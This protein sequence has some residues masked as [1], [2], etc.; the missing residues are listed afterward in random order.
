MD[1]WLNVGVQGG[2]I[3]PSKEINIDFGGNRLCLKPATKDTE[4]SVHINLA[5]ISDRDALTLINRFLSVLS[6]CDD[7]PLENR[8]GWSGNPV[9]AA[10]PR[11]SRI[12]GS[13]TVFPFYRTIEGSKKARLSLALFREGRTVNSV[14]F[15][16]LS[17]FKILN[18]FWNDKTTTIDGERKNAIIEGIRETIPKLKCDMALRRLRVLGTTES[19]VPKYLY[20]SGRCAIAHAYA[21]PIIDP[22]DVSDLYRL[23]EDMNIVKAIAEHLIEN[24]LNI[25]RS[26]LA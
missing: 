16:F 24:D 9:P 26:I 25:S 4:Q 20:G 3:W 6:W 23:S 12:L 17:Y 10:V 8:Y 7:Q 11:E 18:I 19:D 21:D 5:N 15:A 22:D 13:S 1:R 14:P 2:A